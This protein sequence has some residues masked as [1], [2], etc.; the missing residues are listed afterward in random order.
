M[1]V[2]IRNAPG[3]PTKCHGKQGQLTWIDLQRKVCQVSLEFG[4]F[5]FR[6][7]QILGITDESIKMRGIRVI[8]D[9]PEFNFATTINGTRD[10]ICRYYNRP[11]NVTNDETN[12][13]FVKPIAIYFIEQEIRV[14]L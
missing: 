5:W 13:K 10:E 2:T 6:E 3:L 7:T 8:F 9:N 12:E 4:N 14:E 1:N 11:I